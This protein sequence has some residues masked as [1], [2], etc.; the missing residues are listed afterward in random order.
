[1]L[2]TIAQLSALLRKVP[3]TIYNEHV[4]KGLGTLQETEEG[5]RLLFTE[6]EYAYLRQ[7]FDERQKERL[8]SKPNVNRIIELLKVKPMTLYDIARALKLHKSTVQSLLASMSFVFDELAEDQKGVLY[9]GNKPQSTHRDSGMVRH[10]FLSD[11]TGEILCWMTFAD[12]PIPSDISYALLMTDK[13]LYQQDVHG[14]MAY[15]NDII[16]V[17]GEYRLADDKIPEHFTITGNIH[18]NWF[19]TE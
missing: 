18:K 9:F 4:A 11:I 13:C 15:E 1:M 17:N 16:C 8:M 12:T 19:P 14:K 10:V 6:Q 2:Y 3:K 5:R 7:L